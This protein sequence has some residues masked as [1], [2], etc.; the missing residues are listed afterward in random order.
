MPL[1][2]LDDGTVGY[3]VAHNVMDSPQAFLRSLNAGANTS[4]DNGPNPAGVQNTIAVAGIEPSYSDIK[5]LTI[6]AATF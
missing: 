4:D 1:F 3:D 6:P 2:F 5:N